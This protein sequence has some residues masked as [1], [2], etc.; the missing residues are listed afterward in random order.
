MINIVCT[1]YLCYYLFRFNLQKS[2]KFRLE[3]EYICAKENIKR[4]QKGKFLQV[5]TR[6]KL[7][8]H[9]VTIWKD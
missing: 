9:N 8:E 1:Q 6:Y 3:N 4:N 7:T 5:V 2:N